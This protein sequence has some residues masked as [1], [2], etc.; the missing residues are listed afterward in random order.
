LR[1]CHS[2]IPPFQ[3][4]ARRNERQP[5]NPLQKTCFYLSASLSNAMQKYNALFYD[6]SFISII[7]TKNE[8]KL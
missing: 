7:F 6:A 3:K 1:V 8:N 5:I 4:A 2:T